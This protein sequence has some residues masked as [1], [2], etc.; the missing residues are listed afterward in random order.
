MSRLTHRFYNDAHD[1]WFTMRVV[2][3]GDAY[4]RD[5]A[6][7]H[8]GDDPL[9]EFY[10]GRWDHDADPDGERLG[11]FVSRYR[12]S[13]LMEAGP[14]PGG[15][16]VFETGITLDGANAWRVGPAGMADC[17][18][19]LIDADVVPDPEAERAARVEALTEKIDELMGA[20]LDYAETHKDAGDAY[21][22]LPREG[23]WDYGNGDQ[24]LAGW[25]RRVGVDPRGLEIEE[26]ADLVLDNFR[27]EPGTILD[28]TRN[29]DDLFLVDSFP[30]SEI[31]ERVE[32]AEV[33]PEADPEEW[34][35][36]K[37]KAE[38]H[39]SGDLAYLSSDRVWYAV[40]DRDALEGL[41]A[42]AAAEPDAPEI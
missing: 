22:H 7:T 36:A 38:A 40:I 23:T 39:F 15:S 18:R 19:A 27:M 8:T 4:G 14:G 29:D 26:V 9:V 6:L 35:A 42:E 34:E 33:A 41:I 32:K 2:G 17:L 24:R 28:P 5:M 16:S 31:E 12:L 37:A 21:T 1:A 13:T 3:D 11:Q 30:V 10:D 20:R 25:M